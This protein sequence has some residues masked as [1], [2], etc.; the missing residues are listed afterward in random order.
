MDT[1]E[2]LGLHPVELINLWALRMLL[3][4]GHLL[5]GLVGL[6]TFGCW[7]PGIPLWASTRLAK[8]RYVIRQRKDYD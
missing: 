8:Y 1:K 7:Y 5:E 6:L 4:I 3:G 2:I